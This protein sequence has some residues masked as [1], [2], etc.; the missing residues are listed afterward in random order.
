ML[1]DERQT[2][3]I[4]LEAFAAMNNVARRFERVADQAKNISQETL[5]V[6]TGDYVKHRDLMSLGVV[7]LDATNSRASQIAEAIGRGLRSPSFQFMSAGVDPHPLDPGLIESMRQKGYDL[8]DARSKRTS[9][10]PDIDTAQVFVV[11][12]PR[13]RNIVPANPRAVTLEWIIEDP[14][15]HQR[16]FEFLKRQIDDLVAAILGRSRESA[17]PSQ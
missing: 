8:A 14:A 6:V 9:D 5:Y 17:K 2:G 16:T 3:R 10:I 4:P 11:L 12:S 1:F 13:A 15:D 7:F